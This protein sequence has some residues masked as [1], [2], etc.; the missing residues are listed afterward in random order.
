MGNRRVLTVTPIHDIDGY[1]VAQTPAGAGNLVLDGAL[2]SDGVGRV[3]DAHK[4]FLESAANYSVFIFVIKGTD[5]RGVVI[6]EEI[7][8]PNATTISTLKYFKTVTSISINGAGLGPI[9]IGTFFESC[10]KWFLFDH[11]D[12]INT[13]IFIKRDD[14]I[15]SIVYTA[16][17]TGDDINKNEDI[18]IK[19]YPHEFL[20]NITN[21]DIDGNYSS[22]ALAGRVIVTSALGNSLTVTIIETF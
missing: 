14:N 9:N 2:V 4:V 7:S 5:N 8:G 16:E 1:V 11:G 19:T 13:G 6:S 3:D 15:N 21:A 10:T 22:P 18:E 17:H 20:V 12:H